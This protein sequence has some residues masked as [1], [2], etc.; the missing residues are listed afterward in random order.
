MMSQIEIWD[1]QEYCSRKN[2]ERKQGR[3]SAFSAI[4]LM[5]IIGGMILAVLS[6]CLIAY[7]LKMTLEMTGVYYLA[8]G[9]GGAAAGLGMTILGLIKKEVC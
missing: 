3:R 6:G 2:E 5:L 4:S 7:V 1:M 9:I 8:M